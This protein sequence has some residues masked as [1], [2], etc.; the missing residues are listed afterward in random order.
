MIQTFRENR[1]LS[2]LYALVVYA[3]T[4]MWRYISS[5]ILQKSEIQRWIDENAVKL[6]DNHIKDPRRR[7]RRMHK[8]ELPE[9]IFTGSGVQAQKEELPEE[10]FTE[11]G[12]QAQE[13]EKL[14]ACGRAGKRQECV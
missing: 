6:P 13:T 10:I 9:E 2:Q 4:Y 11:S 7:A 3:C 8:E 1:I 5:V 12:V 14:I